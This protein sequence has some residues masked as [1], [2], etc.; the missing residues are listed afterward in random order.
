MKTQ[1][2]KMNG[3]SLAVFAACAG[4][5]WPAMAQQAPAAPARAASAAAA[6]PN[7]DK[8]AL[9]TVVVSGFRG[10]AEDGLRMKRDADGFV[11]AISA[12]GLGRFPE[13]NVGEALTRIP[14]IQLDRFTD[15]RDARVSLR[16]LPGSWAVVTVN[17]FSI[18]DP[19]RDTNGGGTPLGMFNSDVFS[20]F[21]VNKSPNASDT[22]GGLSG[23]IDL[24]FRGA[25]QRKDE[26][27]VKVAAEYNTLGKTYAPGAT[28]KVNHRL[29]PNTAV[30]GTFTI[31]KE[32]FRRDEM[33][34]GGGANSV[35]LYPMWFATTN[36]LDNGGVFSGLPYSGT[37]TNR[38]TNPNP[39]FSSV[40]G[41]TN[42][43]GGSPAIV[44][45]T[46]MNGMRFE[47][48][49]QFADY[50]APP[51]SASNVIKKGEQSL[52]IP[53]GSVLGN[54][55]PIVGTG[56]LSRNGV[57]ALAG[58]QFGAKESK[59]INQSLSAGVE[60]KFNANWRVNVT[61]LHADKNL[62][63]AR[64]ESI[65]QIFPK[66]FDSPFRVTADPASLFMTEGGNAFV[67]DMEVDNMSYGN[68]SVARKA[69]NK[70]TALIGT[71]NY[72]D[73]AWHSTT[74][75]NLSQALGREERRQLSLQ[76]ANKTMF[77]RFDADGKLSRTALDGIYASNGS[78]AFMSTGNGS[79]ESVKWLPKNTQPIPVPTGPFRTA[80]LAGSNQVAPFRFAEG[81][82][83]DGTIGEGG[84]TGVINPI[85]TTQKVISKV[86][87][88]QQELERDLDMPFLSKVRLGLRAEQNNF[89]MTQTYSSIYG[90]NTAGITSAL[91]GREISQSQSFFGGKVQSN[92]YWFGTGVDN[93]DALKPTAQSLVPGQILTPIGFPAQINEDGWVNSFGNQNVLDNNFSNDYRVYSAYVV[94]NIDADIFG[95]NIRGNIGLRHETTEKTIVAMDRRNSV[96]LTTPL[97]DYE[98][99]T[100]KSNYSYNL[101]SLLL[102]TDLARNVVVRYGY[103]DTYVRPSRSQERPNTAVSRTELANN[104]PLNPSET[105]YTLAM[106]G[107]QVK[108][109][110]AASH[111]VAIEWYNR[112]GSV[113]AFGAY[114]K[115]VKGFIYEKNL[116]NAPE[117]MCPASGLFAGKDYGHGPL[118][119]VTEGN[120]LRCRAV[121][122]DLNNSQSGSDVNGN[123]LPSPTYVTATANAN[124]PNT[125]KVTGFEV[126]LQ[127][128][129]SF[130]PEPWNGFGGSINYSVTKVDGT[131]PNGR[132]VASFLQS[133]K[134]NYN[135]TVYYDQGPFGIRLIYNSRNA[136]TQSAGDQNNFTPAQHD[137][138]DTIVK[139]RPQLDLSTSLRF[140]KNN[141]HVI[142]LDLYNLT[143]SRVET[144]REDSRLLRSSF[145]D[146]R[147][148]TLTYRVT[149]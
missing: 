30:F 46:F 139:A 62:K 107:S 77:A 144:W 34:I 31:K 68:T 88:I 32:N 95:Q 87:G 118:E 97:V 20:A 23:N 133:A 41:A 86:S 89:R 127:Q 6:G 142:A 55:T 110:T 115:N 75:V 106:K 135:L 117:E 143:D 74:N 125:T 19:N 56:K 66:G 15:D 109:Y 73:G 51:P 21:V 138:Y 72:D 129:L 67:T 99:N 108:P 8:T 5:A 92:P 48:I 123:R 69:R 13:L 148:A 28:V 43:V 119:V 131:L 134:N 85:I 124:N 58:M 52:F 71:L 116:S 24:Q 140:G 45:N 103:Y 33:R 47:N 130:L 35:Q 50:Y 84:G 2:P 90:M 40:V 53:A 37:G 149:L 38:S 132:K 76:S 16:G 12:E 111:D 29:S 137:Y 121:N 114:R 145:Y 59:G 126:N 26:V 9:E 70:V 120:Q 27:S 49:A 11:D 17:G 80:N 78:A 136:Y 44:P 1:L 22:S 63:D 104:N 93:L 57:Q 4:M 3:L 79:V 112:K 36:A 65:S 54:T 147:T 105:R 96:F 122:A 14:G 25:L 42:G 60:H 18:A 64:E 83:N 102:S 94:G 146:G 101:P 128:N 82:T 10:A 39:Y 141:S 98:F 81:N 100:Y 7:A 91:G 113:I 61:G